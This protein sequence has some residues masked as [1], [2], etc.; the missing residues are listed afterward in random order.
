MTTR[1]TLQSRHDELLAYGFE[2]HPER[3]PA[4]YT[5]TKIGHRAVTLEEATLWVNP[6]TGFV[7]FSIRTSTL[8]FHGTAT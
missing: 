7:G 3:H 8:P 2:F 5:R 6:Y 4:P 1:P